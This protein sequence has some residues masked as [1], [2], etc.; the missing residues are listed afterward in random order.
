MTI[1]N[2]GMK[3]DELTGAKYAMNAVRG[4]SDK[5]DTI[6]RYLHSIG[7]SSISRNAAYAKVYEHP[8]Y[9][10]VL[11]VFAADDVGYREFLRM[12]PEFRGNPHVPRFIG[13]PVDLTKHVGIPVMAIR[14]ERLTQ[15]SG[16]QGSMVGD[17]VD[18]IRAVWGMDEGYFQEHWK[19]SFPPE[20]IH[21]LYV[22]IR[23]TRHSDE[24]RLDLHSG[25]FMARGT[26]IV[27]T[28]PFMPLNY[29]DRKLP[30]LF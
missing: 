1:L 20:L 8:N 19:G 16:F 28:D 21:L 10:Y 9:D 2:N 23:Y 29:S 30:D 13:Q 27:V 5:V 26:T 17:I 3:L 11:K 12:V 22:L 14:M 7:F 4:D 15:L 24:V 6:T 25:N 18:N